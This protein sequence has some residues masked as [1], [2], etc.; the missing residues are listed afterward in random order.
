[1][2]TRVPQLLQQ[3]VVHVEVH[4]WQDL[5]QGLPVEVD[6]LKFVIDLVIDIG[7]GET[8]CGELYPFDI[9]NP[10]VF[11]FFDMFTPWIRTISP[12]FNVTNYSCIY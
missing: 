10:F 11:F 9:I 2:D 3:L 12:H 1:V 7:V 6:L 8:E 4:P 5:E